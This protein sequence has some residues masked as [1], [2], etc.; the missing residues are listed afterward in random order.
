MPLSSRVSK[1]EPTR[2]HRA[3]C[4]RCSCGWGETTTRR[5]LARVR[6]IL[7]L[8]VARAAR[9]PDRLDLLHERVVD[10]DVRLGGLAQAADGEG[11]R[12]GG[13]GA[14]QL[15]VEGVADHR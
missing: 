15:L 4:A 13:H 5:P 6:L 1:R 3:T 10:L 14:Q 7:I 8:F 9:A 12:F 2:P 11:E